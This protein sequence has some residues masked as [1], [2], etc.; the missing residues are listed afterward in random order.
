MAVNAAPT[1]EPGTYRVDVGLEQITEVRIS[2]LH[3]GTLEK[4]TT[5]PNDWN[6]DPATG[7]L[8]IDSPVDDSREMVI[9]LC[10]PRRPPVVRL[11][12]NADL[13][14]VRVVVGDHVGVESQDYVIDSKEKVLRLLGP[15]TLEAPLQ[16]YV[17]YRV[18]SDPA[19]PEVVQSFGNRGDMDTIRRLLGTPAH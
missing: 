11:N 16:Y 9:V 19:H 14:S 4:R 2:A 13:Q 7:L 10:V 5:D 15:D 17:E 6:Y 3:G 8:R 18:H 1:G 12:A